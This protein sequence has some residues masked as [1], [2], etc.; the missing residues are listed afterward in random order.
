[1]VP[2]SMFNPHRAELLSAREHLTFTGCPGLRLEASNTTKAWTYRYRSPTDGKLRQMKL[3]NWPEMSADQAK[4]AWEKARDARNAGQDVA[5]ERR[6]ARVA[7]RVTP[8]TSPPKDDHRTG[9]A[10]TS[11]P[12][13]QLYLDLPSLAFALCISQTT[14]KRLVRQEGFPKPREL[15]DRRV[16]WLV[17][18]VVEWCESRPVSAM[19]P[20]G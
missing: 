14:I 4:G 19:L 5:A 6:T 11:R 7:A 1:M 8:N 17:R 10:R 9:T 2:T 20:P 12:T 3:G 16:G 18:E 15:S 13:I